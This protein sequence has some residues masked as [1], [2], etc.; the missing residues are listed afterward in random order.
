M[1]GNFFRGT[2]VDQDPRWGRSDMKLLNSMQKAG[3]FAP[4]LETK[5][6]LKRVNLDIM[7]KWVTE[8]L[9]ELL[10]FED[11]IVINLVINMIKAKDPDPR[12]MQMDIT[13]FLEKKSG[14]FMEELWTLLVDAQEQPSGIPAV[15]IQKKKDEIIKRQQ[16][17]DEAENRRRDRDVNS[18]TDRCEKRTGRERPESGDRRDGNDSGNGRSREKDRERR[19]RSRDDRYSDHSR[20]RERDRPGRRGHRAR[21]RER[22]S[23]RRRNNSRSDSEESRSDRFD[24]SRDRDSRRRRNSSRSVSE[25]SRSGRESRRH[26]HRS[27]SRDRSPSSGRRRTREKSPIT[28]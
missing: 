16:Q 5:V 27:R 21:S 18:R 4:I 12:R 10:G 2:T 24:R 6:D 9:I 14:A 23:R 25:E 13:G 19:N 15:F 26:S 28:P 22:D 20:D 1:A 11:D 8:R 17:Q 3:K 7:S